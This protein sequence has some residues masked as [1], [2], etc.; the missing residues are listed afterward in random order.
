MRSY[1]K[2]VFLG[3]LLTREEVDGYYDK[4]MELAR[5]RGDREEIYNTSARYYRDRGDYE[6]STAYM[7]SLLTHYAETGKKADLGSIYIAQSHLYEKAGDYA[8]ALEAMRKGN[9]FRYHSRMDQAQSKLAEMQALYDVNRLELEK[10][11]LAGR[12]KLFLLVAGGI[13]LLLLVH[14]GIM[15]AFV[16]LPKLRVIAA[17]LKSWRKYALAGLCL[18]CLLFSM[19][20][21]GYEH[22]LSLI[23][24]SE[25]TRP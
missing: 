3:G 9:D 4:C 1:G 8:K 25:P 13:V 19:F 2:M 23:H 24:I 5:G 10:S 15:A 14:A 17:V 18:V 20:A 12:N 22:Y 11:R 7:D 6:R 16:W 21:Y